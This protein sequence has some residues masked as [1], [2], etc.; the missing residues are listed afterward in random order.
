[1]L[2]LFQPQA[3][4]GALDFV[5]RVTVIGE[6]DPVEFPE[7]KLYKKS[8]LQRIFTPVWYDL[9]FVGEAVTAAMFGFEAIEIALVDRT[10]D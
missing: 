8:I 6:K 3:G 7:D 1:M 2:I 5:V 4:E 9:Y 10:L